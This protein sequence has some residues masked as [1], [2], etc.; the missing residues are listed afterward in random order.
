MAKRVFDLTLSC[1]GLFLS[2]PLW[3]LLCWVIC[4]EDGPPIFYLQERLGKQGRIFK[5]IK[6][7]TMAYGN[8]N[9][10]LARLLRTSALDELP[11]LINIIKGEMSFVGPRPLIPQEVSPNEFA[12]SRLSVLP[13]LTGAAQVRVAKDSPF[14]QKAK[15]D[16]W[17]IEN[18]S[19]A[20]DIM[21]ILKSFWISLARRWDR[22]GG[23]LE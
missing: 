11:Q 21:L 6:F 23:R 16:I 8:Q 17:Y 10:K 1:V 14:S 20:L 12:S 19:L 7:R 9:P 2:L 5:A 3:V 4:L 18:R 15:Y 13:G 22:V